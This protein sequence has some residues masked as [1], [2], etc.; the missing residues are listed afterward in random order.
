MTALIHVAGWTLVSFLWQGAVIGVVAAVALHLARRATAT[1]RYVIGC[2]AL[3][4]ML[5]MPVITAWWLQSPDRTGR[6]AVVE[7]ALP[8]AAFD[9]SGLDPAAN[10]R[11]ERLVRSA[12]V[13]SRPAS[14]LLLLVALWLMGVAWL[15]ARM[16]FGWRRV[17]QLHRVALATPTS[18]WQSAATRLAAFLGI[19]RRVHVAECDLVDAPAV[20]GWLRPVIVMPVAALANL[21]PAQADAILAHEL[22]HI[23]RHDYLVNLAQAVA[24]TLLFYHPA[25]WWLS[26]RLRIEREHC[27]DDVALCVCG[28]AVEYAEAL[29]A[30]E[31]R[32][33]IPTFALAAAG[34][35]LVHRIR[36]ILGP[37]TA[38]SSSIAW[39]AGPALVAVL[40]VGAV[41]FAQVQPVSPR[42]PA[43]TAPAPP[44]A[45]TAPAAPAQPDSDLSSGRE[46][47]MQSSDGLRN[48][49][50][51]GRGAITFA[52][53][54]TD[55][56]AMADGAYLTIRDRN[57]FTVRSIELRG[58]RGGITRKFFVAGREQPWEPEGR[59][60][61]ADRLPPLV[62]RAGLA[63]E[64]RTRRILA[65]SGVNGVL[66]EIKLL[67]TDYVRR[68]YYRELFRAASFDAATAARIVASAGDTIRSDFELRQT[69]E[70]A[71]PFVAADAIAVRAYV[72][73]AGSIGSDFEHRQVLNAL[74]RANSLNGVAV[75]HMAR[76]AARIGSDFE[77]RQA[78]SQLIETPLDVPARRN[79]V[80]EAAATI[81][82]DFECATLLVRFLEHQTLSGDSSA[83]FFGAV[84]TIGSD[85]ERGRVLKAV[86]RR[87][88]LGPDVLQGVFQA[89]R[90]MRSDFEQAEVL[91]SILRVHSIDSAARPDLIA[92][93]DTIHSDYEQTRVLAALVRAE[94]R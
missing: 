87:Q 91:L 15:T 38:A 8:G 67:E 30:I 74:A 59:Q 70:A 32:R 37:T 63:V 35:S 9:A 33:A 21:T 65:T 75:E 79:A 14:W 94:R 93:T 68:L 18:H 84:A 85:Y 48:R 16:V 4:A 77:K 49:E 89:V 57:W 5:A 76:S 58:E 81:A 72:D 73:A 19:G 51:R 46:F 60:W 83:A 1:T 20:V 56:V 88:S 64:S 52:D 29:A 23:Q 36:R 66:E 6:I 7:R 2:A 80:L 69:L 22:A 53:D 41:G 28:D 92:A 61:L 55:V 12:T 27:C 82:S 17:R 78:L 3:G 25:V 13:S 90:N 47:R 71:V 31:M 34:G 45:P 24:E 62:R 54:L 11:A 39:V 42:P 26:G 86:A 43:P 10:A 44:A 50:V 40:M